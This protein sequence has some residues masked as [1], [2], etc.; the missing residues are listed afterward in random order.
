MM[1]SKHT[2]HKPDALL[3]LLVTLGVMLTSTAGASG[4][5]LSK[6]NLADLQDGDVTLASSE[7]S[8]AGI[9]MSLMSPSLLG[10]SNQSSHVVTS[11]A[12]TLPN[13]YLSLRLP[14]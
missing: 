1:K 12:S 14:W 5:F 2:N 8:G 10:G 9:H 4:S 13:I 11:S 6:P 3:A 7:R